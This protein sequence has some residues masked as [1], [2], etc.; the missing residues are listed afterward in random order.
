VF[1]LCALTG[2]SGGPDTNGYRVGG[3]VTNLR[4]NGLVLAAS[5]PDPTSPGVL[6]P[7]GCQPNL[8]IPAGATRFQFANRVAANTLCVVEIL[9]QP[10]PQLCFLKQPSGDYVKAD[11]DDIAVTCNAPGTFRFTGEEPSYSSH[12]A[13]LLRNGKVLVASGFEWPTNRHLPD[14][15]LYDPA[16]GTF[17]ATGSLNA[18]RAYHSA[19]LLLDG[20]VLVAGGWADAILDSAEI[21]DP[22]KGTFTTVGSMAASRSWHSA[23][24][25]PDGKVLVAGG[26]S[27]REEHPAKAPAAVLGMA[28]KKGREVSHELCDG[29]LEAD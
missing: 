25:L 22:T 29:V 9:S 11:M 26:D 21:Y 7:S 4:T 27:C 5:S 16:T 10:S 3:T 23:T 18:A 28:L 1:I 24:L 20:R 15:E 19:T 12:S 14:A 8:A 13:T 6:K 17:T 2:C